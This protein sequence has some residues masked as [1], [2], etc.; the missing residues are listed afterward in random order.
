MV[1]VA[2]AQNCKGPTPGAC[3]SIGGTC[4]I[5][6]PIRQDGC[7][8]SSEYK[9]PFLPAVV[10]VGAP[11]NSGLFSYNELTGHADGDKFEITVNS[12]DPYGCA[13][14]F[15][16]RITTIEPQQLT[17]HVYRSSGDCSYPQNYTQTLTWVRR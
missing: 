16:G 1:D 17:S 10:P 5:I 14:V 12:T 3:Q 6:V 4:R 11:L 15:Y 13:V 7:T 8:I 9:T 2:V